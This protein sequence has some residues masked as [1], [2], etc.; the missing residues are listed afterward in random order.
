MLLLEKRNEGMSETIWSLLPPVVT[1]IIGDEGSLHVAG[2]W[3]FHGCFHVC[4]FSVLGAI[5]TMFKIMS[6]K[7]G[8]NVYILVFLVLTRYHGSGHSEIRG[9]A[10]IWRLCSAHDQGEK[11]HFSSPWCSVFWFFIDDYFNC[12]TIRYG[13]ASGHRPL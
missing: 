11:E 4:G 9:F 10:G 12:L 8:G 7:V 6:D 3:H 5:D 2:H 13:H 1:I